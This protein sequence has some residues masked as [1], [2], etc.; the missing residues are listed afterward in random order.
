MRVHQ[1]VFDAAWRRGMNPIDEETG[2]AER[3]SQ[4]G[5]QKSVP[6]R[7]AVSPPIGQARTKDDDAGTGRPP[8]EKLCKSERSGRPTVFHHQQRS[9]EHHRA[10]KAADAEMAGAD[11]GV[12]FSSFHTSALTVDHALSIKGEHSF[13][14]ETFG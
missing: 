10:D 4:R 2:H 7:S 6:S 3:Q 11:V 9:E 1:E 12:S 5:Q 14:G 13:C 8:A